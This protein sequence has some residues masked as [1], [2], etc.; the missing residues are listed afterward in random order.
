MKLLLRARLDAHL[1]LL[2]LLL[3][4]RLLGLWLRLLQQHQ[5]ILSLALDLAAVALVPEGEIQI[6]AE[7]ADPVARAD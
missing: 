2:L 5:V 4:L 7:D 3:L 6:V 1:M